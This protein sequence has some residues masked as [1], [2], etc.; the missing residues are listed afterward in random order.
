MRCTA[1]PAGRIGDAVLRCFAWGRIRGRLFSISCVSSTMKRAKKSRI[2][3]ILTNIFK[4][5]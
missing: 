4:K 5:S 2:P 1:R 3:C